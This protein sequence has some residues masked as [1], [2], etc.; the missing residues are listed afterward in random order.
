MRAYVYPVIALLLITF[1]VSCMA[2]PEVVLAV[3]EGT[4][5]LS[6]KFQDGWREIPRN[7]VVDLVEGEWIFT[8]GSASNCTVE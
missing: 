4:S 3:Q 6:C 2:P 5:K 1:A 7:Q 8:N